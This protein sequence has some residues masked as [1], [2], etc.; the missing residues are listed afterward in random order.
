MDKKRQSGADAGRCCGEK[1]A[2]IPYIWGWSRRL[3]C[4]EKAGKKAQ[5]HRGKRAKKTLAFEVC[6]LYN[7]PV[8]HFERGNFGAERE[9]AGEK[10]FPGSF[11]GTALLDSPSIWAAFRAAEKAAKMTI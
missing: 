9:V 4:G 8:A 5:K 10:R 1:R 3:R 11:R 6:L 2:D 7:T